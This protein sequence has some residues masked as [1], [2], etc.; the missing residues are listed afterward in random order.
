MNKQDLLELLFPHID[1]RQ[2][3]CKLPRVCKKWHEWLGTMLIQVLTLGFGKKTIFTVLRGSN[4]V[5]HGPMTTWHG[6]TKESLSNY[7]NG[8]EHGVSTYYSPSGKVVVT[9]IY[10][11]DYWLVAHELN[12]FPV[13]SQ[14]I[15]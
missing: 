4:G 15:H 12:I 5:K 8:V 11:M 7:R 10:I 1:A 3:W 9:N 13:E 2:T 6:N 14:L